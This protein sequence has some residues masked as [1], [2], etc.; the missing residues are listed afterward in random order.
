MN[1]FVE[2]MVKIVGAV[3]LVV[4]MVLGLGLLFAFP[5]KW[6]VNYVF[7]DGTRLALFGVTHISVWQAYCL[8]LLCGLLFK[9]SGITAGK[10]K[11]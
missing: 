4:G 6:L 5:I 9:G 3:V 11:K 2:G 8:S 1:N 10:E 7:T